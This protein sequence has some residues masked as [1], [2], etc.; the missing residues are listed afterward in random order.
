MR[1]R[2][3]SISPSAAGG[4][5]VSC[6]GRGPA[7][8][9][10]SRCGTPKTLGPARGRSS[11]GARAFLGGRPPGGTGARRRDPA[12]LPPSGGRKGRLLSGWQR[13]TTPTLIIGAEND[14]VAGVRQHAEPFYNS[15][16]SAEERAYLELR[17]AG[18]GAP[19][20]YSPTPHPVRAVVGQAIRGQRHPL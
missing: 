5:A 3:R 16:T 10:G 13:V 6:A 14:A 9:S 19:L 4:A 17:G 18:H 2:L 12:A 8:S 1:S 7:A 15:L 11:R 20:A